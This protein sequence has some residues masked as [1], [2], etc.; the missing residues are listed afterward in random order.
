MDV[1]PCAFVASA[2]RTFAQEPVCT[3]SDDECDSEQKRAALTGEFDMR[4]QV[5]SNFYYAHRKG[6]DA[7]EEYK[8]LRG[9]AAK[10]EYKK[11]VLVF[12]C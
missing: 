1:A 3:N 4:G 8:K 5:G 10:Q 12:G 6:T 7:F 2:F 9:T 11:D